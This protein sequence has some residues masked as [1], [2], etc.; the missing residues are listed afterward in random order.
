MLRFVILILVLMLS[1]PCQGSDYR[2]YFGLKGGVSTITGGDGYK[3]PLNESFGGSAGYRFSDRWHLEFDF[4]IHRNLNDSTA[5]SSLSFGGDDANATQKW[6]ASRLGITLNKYLFNPDNSLNMHVGFGGGLMVWKIVEPV[7][8]TAI[9]VLGVHNERTDFAATEIF[10][11]ARTGFDLTLSSKLALCWDV[12][13]DM[14]TGAGA[15]FETSVKDARNTWQVGSFLTLKYAFGGGSGGG[16]KSSGTWSQATVAAAGE[17]SRQALDG[18]GDGVPD[19]LDRCLD[20]PLGAIVNKT[21]CAIDSDADGISDGLDDCAG[22]D[23]RAAGMVDI[24]GCPIDSDFDGMPDYLDKCPFNQVGARV[25]S[26]GCPTDSDGDGVPDG[27][28]DCPYT[29][30]G[31][32]VDKFGCI[33]LT[34][35]SHPMVLNIDY[36]PG[37]FE[38]DPNNQERLRQLARILNFVPEIRLEIS[39]YTDNIGTDVANQKLSEK[40]ANRVRDYL[41]MHGVDISRI[42]VFGKGETN[43]VAS[44]DT[45]EGRAKNRRIEIIFYK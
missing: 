18:D 25:D 4:S 31:V 24:Y 42:K 14:L 28:D 27:I 41:A 5:S 43:F 32:D 2:Y 15:E 39:G 1:I 3:F 37:S 44:N 34:D 23:P 13:A 40:R 38:V 19:E 16:W 36:P 20:T 9:D 8:D 7:G 6:K 11:T 21:G 10:V 29:L 17:S 26:S 35:F 30:Y 22:T 33:D 45:A 12:Q